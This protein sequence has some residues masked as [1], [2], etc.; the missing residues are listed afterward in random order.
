MPSY[1]WNIQT[2]K[3]L[4]LRYGIRRLQIYSHIRTVGSKTTISLSVIDRAPPYDM[5]QGKYS[6]IRSTSCSVYC[7]PL[8]FHKLN[9]WRRVHCVLHIDKENQQK[10][11]LNLNEKLLRLKVFTEV[12]HKIYYGNNVCARVTSCQYNNKVRYK[13]VRQ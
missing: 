5:P 10:G 9:A 12:K 8:H 1:S 4:F 2:G 11:P 3:G 6:L 7:C 13:N